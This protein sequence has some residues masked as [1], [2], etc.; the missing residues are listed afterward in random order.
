MRPNPSL[1]RTRNLIR[2]SGQADLTLKGETDVECVDFRRYL[3]RDLESGL[4]SLQS[5]PS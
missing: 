1:Q 3:E 5:T 4:F 2:E